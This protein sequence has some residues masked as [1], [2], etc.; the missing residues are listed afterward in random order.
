VSRKQL[1]PGG[2]GGATSGD[3][4][5][6]TVLHVDMDAF[7]A[8][9]TLLDHPELRGRPV[10]IGGSNR[11]VVL[12][13]TYEAR[14]MGVHSAMPMAR[15]RRACPQAVVLAPTFERY[16]EV[17]HAV[18]EIFRSVTPLV[19]QISVDEAFLD[20]AGAVRRLGS[21]ATIGAALRAQVEAELRVTCS[22]GVAGNK[23]LAKLGS[24]QAK[25]DGLLVV[26]RDEA[27][28]F[29]HPLPLGALWGVGER[30]EKALHR[31]GLRTV[32]D[33]AHTPESALAQVV[34]AASAAHLS[35]LAWGRDARTVTPGTGERSVGAE[36]TF[37]RDV[38]DP[39]VVRRELLRLSDR[40]AARVRAAGRRGRTVAI[41]VRHADF[42]TVTRSRTLAQPTDV[43]TEVYEAAVGLYDA[44]GLDRARL[45]LVGVR[46]ENLV[47]ADD[48][49]EQLLLDQPEHGW[50]DADQAVDRAG[51]RF[52]PGVVS[53]ARLVD[54]SRPA[55]APRR[56]QG[57]RA[58]RRESGGAE[59]A[60]QG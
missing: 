32:G 35:A 53:K 14:R 34:G 17:S 49:A 57:G 59:P 28:A 38:D 3:D 2:S 55:P 16:R 1:V 39:A 20:V 43:G 4:T 19:E 45:R 26:P 52:G 47:E 30:T 33:L 13:A 18:M 50:R 46:V 41:K 44:M 7:F 5:G 29:L 31:L 24:T 23:F 15:A 56:E 21:P 40:V 36:H 51:A 8:S 25:P 22:V 48:H 42:T 54:P 58:H 60:D 27:V 9:V 12:S 10:I 11:G 6:C 37:E